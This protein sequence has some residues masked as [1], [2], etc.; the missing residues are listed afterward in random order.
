MPKMDGFKL[1][2]K[3]KTNKITCHIPVILLT[4]RAGLEDKIEG[5]ETGADVFITKPFDPPELQTR[6]RNLIRQRQL[7]REAFGSEIKKRE[8]ALIRHISLT[9][10]NELDKNFIKKAYD[11]GF[12]TM[13]YFNKCFQEQYGMTPSAYMAKYK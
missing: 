8:L 2:R 6:V 11:V 3:L 9:G 13:P 5:L 10:L 4:A 1:C 7:L 12:N